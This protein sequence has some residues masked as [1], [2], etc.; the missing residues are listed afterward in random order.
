M[1]F[2]NLSGDP[3][4][5]SVWVC[6]Y[7]SLR[8][9][10]ESLHLCGCRSRSSGSVKE[11]FGSVSN[12]IQWAFL[13]SVCKYSDIHRLCGCILTVLITLFL[14]IHQTLCSV[15]MQTL[16]NVCVHLPNTHLPTLLVSVVSIIVL[17]IAKELNNRCREKLPV[18]VPV[19]L[20][21]V[22]FIFFILHF[23]ILKSLF[24]IS[25]AFH[26]Y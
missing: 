10:S 19:E 24:M 3:G 4:Y 22:C 9:F 14:R 15:C 21:I 1:Y 6:R 8:A 20:I 11:H 7:I 2:L 23:L 5:G 26:G 25:T 12:T 18:P 16:A 17:I 13:F